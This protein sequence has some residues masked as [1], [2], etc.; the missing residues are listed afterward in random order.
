MNHT[1]A[2]KICYITIFLGF[3]LSKCVIESYQITY[4][5]YFIKNDLSCPI[6]YKSGYDSTTATTI[7][8]G[9]RKKIQILYFE[10]KVTHSCFYYGIS[11]KG[12]VNLDVGTIS[13]DDGSNISIAYK[14]SDDFDKNPCFCNAWKIVA[15][16]KVMKNCYNY[17][18]EYTV[19][20]EDY[21]NALAQS[22]F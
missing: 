11:S 1:K 7:F 2:I 10:N 14:K 13:F 19:D 8:P 18:V 21:R 17:E 4:D 16:E 15:K 12:I 9:E 6:T 20:E 5:T 3:M 22:G